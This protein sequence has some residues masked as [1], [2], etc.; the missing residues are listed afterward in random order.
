MFSFKFKDKIVIKVAKSQR[1]FKA[2][3]T[4]AKER[5]GVFVV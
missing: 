5:G 4:N 1:F 2:Y 3:L